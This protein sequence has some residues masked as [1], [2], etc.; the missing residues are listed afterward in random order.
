MFFSEPETTLMFC[1]SCTTQK[2]LFYKVLKASSDNYG[3]LR[4]V[5]FCTLRAVGKV[6]SEAS[7]TIV[8]HWFYNVS[9]CAPQDSPSGLPWTQAEPVAGCERSESQKALFYKVVEACFWIIM[10]ICER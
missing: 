8:S 1:F 7:G 3:I 4:T 9:W 5:G 6:R 2:A 10:G